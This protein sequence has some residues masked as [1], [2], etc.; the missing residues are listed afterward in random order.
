M[1]FNK[2]RPFTH[3]AQT[4][5]INDYRLRPEGNCQLGFIVWKD[6]SDI[7]HCL[8]I[9]FKDALHKGLSKGL[10]QVAIEL[11]FEISPKAKLVDIKA[12][13]ITHPALSSSTKLENLGKTYRVGKNIS[14]KI[15]LCNESY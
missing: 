6:E 5:N 13:V 15:S 10:K 7:Q 9:F 14:S 11:G 12:M 3:T 2:K 4:L 1:I 8:D